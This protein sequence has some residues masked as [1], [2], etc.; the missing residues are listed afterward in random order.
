[1]L[2]VCLE[3][4]FFIGVFI[5]YVAKV[6][7]VLVGVKYCVLY[8]GVFRWSRNDMKK[9]ELGWSNYFGKVLF[10]FLL[11]NIENFCWKI[12]LN[13]VFLYFWIEKFVKK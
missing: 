8:I 13:K 1:M 2:K 4:L 3:G 11:R 6:Y 5:I 12:Y 9:I 10:G 7:W